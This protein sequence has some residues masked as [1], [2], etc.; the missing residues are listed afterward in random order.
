MKKV[1]FFLLLLPVV[2]RAQ[3]CGPFT[4]SAPIYYSGVHDKV[5]K[6]K[7]I[8]GLGTWCIKLENCYNVTIKYCKLVNGLKPAIRLDNCHNITIDS[9]YIANTAS[10]LYAFRCDSNIK[11]RH[12]LVLNIIGSAILSHAAQMNECNGPG[13]DISYNNI[14]IAIGEGDNPNPLIGDLIN[15]YKSNGTPSSPIRIYYNNIRG[16]GTA[17]GSKGNAGIVVGDLGGSY[18]DVQYNKLVN[19]GYVGIQIQGGTH[20]AIRNNQI[21]SSLRPWSGV[22]LASANYSGTPSHHNTISD[23]VV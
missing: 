11:F 13:N 22:G 16:G 21:Y 1:L 12:N 9:N 17:T 5:I 3:Y 4:P 18:Q 10:G 8:T 20:I 15:L 19:T 6:S 23:N 7:L 2:A 14:D